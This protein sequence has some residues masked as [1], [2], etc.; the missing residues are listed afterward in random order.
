MTA[1]V[2]HEFLLSIGGYDIDAWDGYTITLDMLAPGSPWTFE[3]WRV[4][5]LRNTWTELLSRALIFERV[6]LAIDGVVMLDGRIRTVERIG[7]RSRAA[8]VISGS[9]FAGAAMNAG[10]N[11]RATFRGLTLHSALERLFEPLG[12][13]IELGE[14]VDPTAAAPGIR[15]PR[16]PS[17]RR[18]RRAGVVDRFRPR[19]GETVWQCAD[20]LCRKA[21][22]LLWTAPSATPDRLALR[23][24]SPRS[25]GTSRFAFVRELR[26][27][28]VTL[29]SNI[30]SGRDRVSIDGVPSAVTVFADQPRGDS[31][32]ARTE[33]TVDNDQFGG[34][35]FAFILP[36][37]PQYVLSS[38]ARSVGA[39]QREATRTIGDANRGL[40][41]YTCTVQGHGQESDGAFVLY[42]PNE[43]ARVRDD[44]LGVELDG[45]IT[46]VA[47][48]GGRG[49]GGKGQTTELTIV[50]RGA[51]K[52]SPESA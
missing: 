26:D 49:N 43:L 11:P 23:V 48:V 52:V 47:F 29:D 34:S 25:T 33:R 15:P 14:G 16:R 37:Q 22:Y 13:A 18:Q 45:L 27:G 8:L 40:H 24:D 35:R 2:S 28:V 32:A 10:A 21:G 50:P 39:A 46:R 19:V 3:L 31:T 30:L 17:R 7:D 4:E 42:A 9:D 38:R 5:G 51:I 20:A 12:V 6:T 44:V 36:Q 1:I 41:R